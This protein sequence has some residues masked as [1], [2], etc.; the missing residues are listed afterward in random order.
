MLDTAA[1]LDAHALHA[2]PEGLAAEGLRVLIASYRSHPHVGGQGVYVRELS[3]ALNGLGA[4]VTVVSG[5]PYPELTAGVTLHKLPSLDLFSSDNALA[6]FRPAFLSRW[7]DLSE[8]WLHNTG[9]FGE[10]YAFGARLK[11][12]LKPRAGEF[13]VVH[14]NQGLYAS[15]PGFTRSG[16]TSVATL[17]HPITIDRDLALE[18]ADTWIDRALIRRWH[19]FLKTQAEVARALPALLTVSHA[20]KKA[21]SDAFG[22]PP[23]QISVAFNGVD[24][25]VFHPI[26]GQEREPGLIAATASADTPLKGLADLLRAFAAIAREA[27]GARLV[28]V[29][30][31]RDGPAKRELER[32][33]LSA[34]VSFREGVSQSDLADLY[35]RAAVVAA[36]SRFEGFGF[37]AAE[38]MACGACVLATDGGALPEVVADAGVIVPAGQPDALARAAIALLSDDARREAL[39]VAAAKRAAT[40]FSWRRHAL[41][42]VATYARARAHADRRA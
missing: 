18:A 10:M 23:E 16:T 34:R 22:V 36:P 32:S 1:P 31:L 2:S 28:V 21:A 29:G 40:A 35:R 12:W 37:P 17:H 38:A 39:G 19:G 27:P 41:A 7:P 24:T 4:R 33:G 13:E 5:P 26:K 6:E 42:A 25:N 15:L 9:A 3:R 14:D 20:S 11:Q 30:R 8:W